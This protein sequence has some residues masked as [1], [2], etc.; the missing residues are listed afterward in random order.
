MSRRRKHNLKAEPVGFVDPT[1][2]PST[3]FEQ[4]EEERMFARAHLRTQ[5]ALHGEI[6]PRSAYACVFGAALLCVEAGVEAAKAYD[7]FQAEYER[8]SKEWDRWKL[9][10]P[11]RLKADEVGDAKREPTVQEQFDS[12]SRQASLR[13]R[14]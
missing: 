9:G 6:G 1:P 7:A 4:N 14:V 12:N 8:V 5:K 11:E 3:R 13:R 10:E 2:S